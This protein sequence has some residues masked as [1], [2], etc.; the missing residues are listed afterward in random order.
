MRYSIFVPPENTDF[1]QHEMYFS[2]DSAFQGYNAPDQFYP[3]GRTFVEIHVF[4]QARR[5]IARDR[6]SMSATEVVNRLNSARTQTFMYAEA[7]L[8]AVQIYDEKRP[9]FATLGIRDETPNPR[10]DFSARSRLWQEIQA[11][12]PSRDEQLYNWRIAISRIK[13]FDIDPA[14]LR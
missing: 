14:Q 9:Q 11:R 12:Y 4:D 13:L 6:S 8:E 10:A 7:Y 3:L 5:K 1:V 2:Y